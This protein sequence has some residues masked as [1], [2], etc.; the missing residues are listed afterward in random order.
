MVKEV[1]HDYHL[2][3][4]KLFIHYFTYFTMD[5]RKS[6]KS[7]LDVVLF[8][9][10]FLVTFIWFKFVINLMT[11]LICKYQTYKEH[12]EGQKHKKKEAAL[13][14]GV[15]SGATNGP[16]GVQTQLRC[17]LCDVS[18]T[19]V[20]AYAAHIRGSKHQKVTTS[21]DF[22]KICLASKSKKSSCTSRFG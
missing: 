5:Q 4:E 3:T 10:E 6:V 16:R 11:D 20:D 18:C 15:Q 22:K 9:S 21:P 12:L 13:K 2:R 8:Y 17:E 19:G 14:T 1:M 7:N